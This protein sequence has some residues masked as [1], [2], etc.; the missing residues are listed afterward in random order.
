VVSPG[1]HSQDSS[2]LSAHDDSLVQS[3][4]EASEALFELDIGDADV[5]F[6]LEGTWQASLF[7]STGFLIDPAGALIYPFTFPGW[8][9]GPIFQQ[10]PDLTFSV[11]LLNR[12]FIEA[13]VIGDFL[14]E[15]YSYFDQNYILMGYVGA[16]GEFLQR[17]LIGS[18]D[19]GIDPFP[20]LE[21]PEPGLSSLGAEAL[22]QT[23]ISEHQLLLRYDNNET[24]S[25]TFIGKNL[26]SEQV[27]SLDDYIQG[28]F[29][30]LPDAGVDEDSLEVYIEDPDGDYSDGTGRRYRLAT[31]DDAFL[32]SEN[33]TVFLKEAAEGNVLVFYTKSGSDIGDISLDGGS[34]V[35][36]S[37]GKI[38]L[39]TSENF[40]WN[41]PN[42]DDY[43]GRDM[44]GRQVSI[45]SKTCLRLYQ[46]GEFSPFDILAAYALEEFVPDDLSSLRV[47]IVRKGKPS[48]PIPVDTT[49]V[50]FRLTPG[51]DYIQAYYKPFNEPVPELRDDF[52]NL[53]PFL[54]Y[55]ESPPIFDPDNLIYGPLADPKPGYLDY[56]I[57]VSRLTPVSEYQIGPDAVPGS[58]QILRNGVS[59]TRFEVDYDTGTIT[60][61]TEIGA[62]DRLDVS[63]RRKLS[64]ANL[65]DLLFAWGNTLRF[66]EAL[67][68]DL[69]TGVRWNFLPGSYTDEAYSRTGTV[70][71]SAGLD[72]TVG[73]LSY[74]AAVAGGYTNPDTTG[75]MRLLSMETTGID[76]PL[77]EDTAYPAAP[78]LD[79]T[80]F[81]PATLDEGNRGKLFYKDYRSYGIL[82][83]SMLMPYTWIP[84]DDQQFDYVTGSK[85]GPYLAAGSYSGTSSGRSLVLDFELDSDD[86]VGIQ[87]PLLPGQG[88]SDLSGLQ[89]ISLRYNVVDFKNSGEFSIYLQIGE[90]GEDLDGDGKIDG[91]SSENASGWKV[92]E[93]RFTAAEK[94]R[95]SRTR[96]LRVLV[97]ENGIGPVA[98]RVLI[99]RVTLVGSRFYGDA[100]DFPSSDDVQIR[101]LEESLIPDTA[102]PTEKLEDAFTTVDEIFHPFGETQKVLEIHW[103][104]GTNDDWEVRGYTEAQPEGIDYRNI[105]Y[106]Y[107]HP[108]PDG[109]TLS[110]SLLDLPETDPDA[111]GIS[112]DF[113]EHCTWTS[114]ISPN[115][116][117]RWGRRRHWTSS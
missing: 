102:A 114:C 67:N 66:S 115:P 6:F 50:A 97:V 116:R 108:A 3:E 101:E 93:H 15:E 88:V 25:L 110:F 90:I 80:D 82:G 106:Y 43:F 86:W 46:P 85:P 84:P 22:M 2:D 104:N 38:D 42:L 68:L 54:D 28:R 16:E 58:V 60:F 65:G 109:T 59:E 29:F 23:G 35:G 4:V 99:D 105:V 53:Y 71:V 56:E 26:V 18:R 30:K 33:G 51:E 89:G 76:V 10:T 49:E 1:P 74:K 55:T 63:F 20:F 8:E 31:V 44:D 11:W 21:V 39:A 9:S 69:A 72:G 83:D 64:L 12:Y 36:E 17:L 81:L 47:S 77:S 94:S 95:L 37:A 24:G 7:G 14:E 111:R 100:S 98:A 61:L 70:L 113:Q 41:N 48:N 107:R 57:L 19:I 5:D 27:I 96:S 79:D 40:Y 45:G 62:D 13:S 112:W 75:I 52:R 87:L 78:P 103:E 32:D 91:E 92:F 117:E 73:P 34:L